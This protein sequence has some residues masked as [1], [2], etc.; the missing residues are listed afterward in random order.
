MDEALI[1]NWNERVQPDDALWHVGDFAFGRDAERIDALFGR[2]NG[3]KHLVIGNHDEDNEAVMTLPWVSTSVIATIAVDDQHVTLCHYPMRTWPRAR[4]AAIHLFGHMHGRWRGTSRSLDV[5][6]DA[7]GFKPV[8][9]REI[10]QRLKTL[11][12][13]T[14]FVDA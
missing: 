4:K 6:A 8:S 1:R 13:D 5:G 10:R 12:H 14:D 7:W 11:P 3:E 9:L 2:L